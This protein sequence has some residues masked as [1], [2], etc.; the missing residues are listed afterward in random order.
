MPIKV[1]DN[2]PAKEILR[3]ENIFLMDETQ[4]CH[5]DIRPLKIAIVN[6]MPL[7]QVTE[8]QF[9][10]LLGNSPLQVDV[11]F[12][13]MESHLSKNTSIEY[14][15]SFY[16]NFDEIKHEKFD[17]MIITGAPVEHLDYEDVTYWD[18]LSKIMEWS[19][20]NV[21]STLHVCWGA[22]AGLYYH[23]KVKKYK[24]S[25][26]MFGI[27][28]HRKCVEGTNLLR[29]FDDVF[30]VPQSRHTDVRREDIE[31][32]PDLEVLSVS[33]V[34][35]VYIAASKDGRHIFVTGHSEYDFD[36]L[37]NEYDRDVKNGSPINIPINYFPGDD[38]TQVPTVSWRAHSNLL[39]I[40]WLNYYVYQITPYDL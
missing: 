27:F 1:A 31:N 12:V 10:R 32:V 38:P 14:L 6:L 7:K 28:P 15:S 30:F 11:K 21:T 24:L 18:E 34:S 40:N 13:Y 2:L 19:N 22:Q 16:N 23:Y 36:T 5:Q 26:K 29:G 8:V 17:G 4:A 37:K 33:D 25:D 35:G 20:T 3:K 39:F 9:L